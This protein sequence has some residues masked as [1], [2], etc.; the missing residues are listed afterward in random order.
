[1]SDEPTRPGGAVYEWGH[2][3]VSPT[4]VLP[5]V[6]PR[7]APSSGS[8]LPVV[9]KVVVIVLGLGMVLAALLLS[10]TRPLTGDDANAIGEREMVRITGPDGRSVEVMAIIDTGATV[11][12]MDTSLARTLGFDLRNAKRVRVSSSLGSERRPVVDAAL[13]IAGKTVTSHINV[14]NRSRRSTQV[15]LGRADVKGF[16]VVVGKQLLTRPAGGAAPSAVKALTALGAPAMDQSALLSLIPLAALVIVLLRVVAGM[17]T[18]GTFSPVLLAISYAQVGL[19]LGAIL[20]VGLFVIGFLAQPLL[21]RLH[22]PRVARLAALVGV[23]VALLLGIQLLLDKELGSTLNVSL[24]VVVTA[25]ITERLWEQWD[26]DG[27]R[28]ALVSAGLTLG[29]GVLVALLMLTPL[30]RYLADEVPLA[31]ALACGMWT[32][33]AGTY[34]GLRL[35]ELMRFPPLVAAKERTA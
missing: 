29:V 21:R 7:P 1:M 11:S 28:A 31:L 5:A 16:H 24:P 18:L 9:V 35:S 8:R 2:G 22:L 33:V 20:T 30:I 19:L 10:P 12:S 23:V 6:D 13:Q 15:L 32:I 14:N 25:V 34:R 3:T 17:S 27:A 4:T 26:A